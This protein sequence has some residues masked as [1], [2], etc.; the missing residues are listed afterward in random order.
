VSIQRT[1]RAIAYGLE[2]I[3]RGWQLTRT[4]VFDVA[5]AAVAVSRAGEGAQHIEP[6]TYRHG[7]TL[8]PIRQSIVRTRRSRNGWPRTRF[9]GTARLLNE[10]ASEQQLRHRSGRCPRK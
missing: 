1:D 9:R 3:S 6:M 4:R 2:R 5:S 10:G 7:G 8:A